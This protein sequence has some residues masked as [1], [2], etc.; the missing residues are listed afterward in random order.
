MW[1]GDSVNSLMLILPH[2]LRLLFLLIHRSGQQ[3]YTICFIT[4]ID[5]RSLASQIL[6]LI[7]Q[8]KKNTQQNTA[9]HVTVKLQNTLS[10]RLSCVGKTALAPTADWHLITPLFI[11]VFSPTPRIRWSRLS[12]AR[13]RGGTLT[14]REWL[15]ALSTREARRSRAGSKSSLHTW[16]LRNPSLLSHTHQRVWCPVS[17][18][19]FFPPQF[20]Y[21]HECF[22]RVFCEL[23]WRKEVCRLASHSWNIPTLVKC[24][25]ISGAVISGWRG[26]DG[27]RQ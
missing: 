18:N 27:Q 16:V 15:S 3:W 25:L 14:R 23:K 17:V 21:M 13:C 12:G 26:S 10:W 1:R 4:T 8:K 22:E 5:S 9:C 2:C 19:S 20:N 6:K 11:F 24:A 7:R